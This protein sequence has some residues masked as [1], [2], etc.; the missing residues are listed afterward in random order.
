MSK[1]PL[2]SEENAELNRLSALV[3]DEDHYRLLDVGRSSEASIVQ[4][5]LLTKL[6]RHWHP[7][8]FFERDVEE[9]GPIIDK[10][11]MGL[12]EAY[13][14]LSDPK[15][16][17]YDRK[18]TPTVSSPSHPKQTQ[19]AQPVPDR[20]DIERDV[21]EESVNVSELN[22][23]RHSERKTVDQRATPKSA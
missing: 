6:S 11:F 9:Y 12:T 7:D 19:V 2:T 13:Q 1:T 16:Q 23:E 8:A 5:G 3:D 20:L 18:H 21:V 22:K 17:I 15:K 4:R 14:V 10:I